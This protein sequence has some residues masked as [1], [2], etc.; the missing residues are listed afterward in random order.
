MLRIRSVVALVFLLAVALSSSC[1]TTRASQLIMPTIKLHRLSALT[2][3]SNGLVAE[4][5]LNIDN[6]N[7]F[8][9]R[10]EKVS[11]ALTF[12]GRPTARGE[13]VDSVEV[14]ARG[15]ALAKVTLRAPYRAVA[16]AGAVLLLMG[17]LPYTLEMW[18]DFYT[19]LGPARV[20]VKEEGKLTLPQLLNMPPPGVA[21]SDN[22]QTP[23]PKP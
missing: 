23:P 22:T 15:S 7:P 20:P 5:Q 11:Y 21:P 6:P 10:M 19:P 16:A 2:F 4:A 18:V 17:E 9:L 12:E 3:D 1:A 14:P 8:P 13:T